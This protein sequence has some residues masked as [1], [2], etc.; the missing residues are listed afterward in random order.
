MG[1]LRGLL[2]ASCRPLE[3]LLGLPGGLLGP[4]G[5]L[6]PASWEP[7][8]ASWGPLGAEGSKCPFG[9]LV[10]APSWSRLGGL[11]GC[12]GGLLG[13]LGPL[14]GSLGALLGASW[15]VLGRREAE[16]ARK[17]K[18][19]KNTTANQQFSLLGALLGGFV[20]ACWAVWAASGPVLGPSSVSWSDIW[21]SGAP[22]GP[23]W[24]L[25]GA[26]LARL[27]ALLG[28]NKSR[29]QTRETPGLTREAREDLA[30]WALVP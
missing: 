7:L 22:I 9:S 13:R 30:I 11:L 27:R 16:K 12:I 1:P 24:R 6:L 18:T 21:A 29:D 26:L 28:P 15:A 25:L 5:G 23:S 2:G 3:G 17:Q 8:G 19:S 14:L 20:N 4:P 10:W